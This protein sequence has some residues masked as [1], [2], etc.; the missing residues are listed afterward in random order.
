M[1]D[2]IIREAIIINAATR[3]PFIDADPG[4]VVANGDVA[5]CLDPMM[6]GLIN[7]MIVIEND[8]DEMGQTADL[9]I[10]WSDTMAPVW[11]E[12][13]G[14][15]AMKHANGFCI[16]DDATVTEPTIICFDCA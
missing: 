2:T 3:R 11:L 12:C 1:T 15:D 7:T 14:C 6:V 10:V 4:L 8:A 16:I 13:P 5:S 9:D